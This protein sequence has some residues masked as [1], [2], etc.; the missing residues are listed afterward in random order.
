MVDLFADL[1]GAPAMAALV[2]LDALIPEIMAPAR[3]RRTREG[4]SAAP[5]TPTPAPVA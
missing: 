5:V 2:K 1:D 3:A 4:N